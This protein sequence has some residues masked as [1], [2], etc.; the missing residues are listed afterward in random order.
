[1]DGGASDSSQNSPI[2]AE[3]L[4]MFRLLVHLMEV[5]INCLTYD[6]VELWQEH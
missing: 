1:V 4:G 5:I 2:L 6:D 3:E